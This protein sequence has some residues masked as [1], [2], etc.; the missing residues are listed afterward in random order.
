MRILLYK[1]IKNE[2]PMK[3][4]RSLFRKAKPIHKSLLSEV[5]GLSSNNPMAKNLYSSFVLIALWLADDKRITPERWKIIFEK[6]MNRPIL[7][8]LFG[9]TNL[10]DPKT[11]KKFGERMKANA[12]WAQEH[13]S[14]YNTW[15]FH[16]DGA[17][18][19]KGFAYYFTH[20][21]IA[22]FCKEH[23]IEEIMDAICPIDYAN[24]AMHHGKLIRE[25]TL[26]K[27]GEI[28]D[29]WVVGDEERYD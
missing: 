27:G 5:E 20:C 22:S 13:P 23:G 24:F 18:H 11:M 21:P 14:D 10:N 12:R 3:D 8:R 9:R 2:C 7:V 16:F 28:C 15:D 29:F 6:A 4:V 25:H 19:R 1:S 26:A 17:V